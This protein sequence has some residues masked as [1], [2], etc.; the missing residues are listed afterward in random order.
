MIN[1]EIKIV[2]NNGKYIVSQNDENYFIANDNTCRVIKSLIANKDLNSAHNEYCNINGRPLTLVQFEEVSSKI[3]LQLNSNNSF[4]K[5]NYL[6]IRFQ[7]LSPRIIGAIAQI[8][9]GLFNNVLFWFLLSA[10]FVINIFNLLSV[11]YL[12][13]NKEIITNVQS[14]QSNVIV[15]IFLLLISPFIHEIGHICGCR[16]FNATHGRVG[17]SQFKTIIVT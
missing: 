1:T 5:Y 7:M 3:L 16:K 13:V 9:V 8:F 17:I 4:L 6:P 10:A 15:Y 2:L 14:S 12:V 11:S